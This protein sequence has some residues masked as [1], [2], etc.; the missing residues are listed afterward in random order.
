EQN[1][2]RHLMRIGTR[3][4]KGWTEASQVIGLPLHVSGIPPL[5]H[6]AFDLPDAQEARTLFTQMMMDR[7]IL[8][9]GSFYAGRAPR[10]AHVDRYLETLPEV[11]REL[12][13][14]ID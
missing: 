3:I 4:Q 1:V 10:D 7:G 9:T 8:A 6:F 11:F 12:R 5:G 2:A 14:A 13:A